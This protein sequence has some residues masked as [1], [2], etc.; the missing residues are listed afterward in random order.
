MRHSD[1][2]PSNP[3]P[4]PRRVLPRIGITMGDPAGIGPEVVLKAVAEEEVRRACIPVIIGDAQL[5]AHT[6]RTLDLQSGYDIIR[7][8][9]EFPDQIS[10][11]VIYHL[12][13]ISGFIE[14]GIESGAAGKAAAGYIEAAVELC[15]AGNIDA[16]A[17]APINKR[18]LFFWGYRFPGQA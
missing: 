3:G 2:S 17:T 8:D 4:R 16:M 9:E 13:N 12:D 6:A 10:E 7:K 18:P 5:L 14:P 15:A 1:Q 11:P